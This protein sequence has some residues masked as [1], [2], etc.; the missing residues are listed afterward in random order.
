M[1]V[2]YKE[3]FESIFHPFSELSH[4]ILNTYS[5]LDCSLKR[6]DEYIALK[7]YPFTAEEVLICLAG[8]EWCEHGLEVNLYHDSVDNKYS[9]LHDAIDSPQF[10]DVQSFTNTLFLQFARP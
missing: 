6:L 1:S 4:S 9:R 2:E 5:F 10:R 8:D 7:H 3:K